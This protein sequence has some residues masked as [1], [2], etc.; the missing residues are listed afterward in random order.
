MNRLPALLA[1]AYHLTGVMVYRSID[2]CEDRTIVYGA[3]GV[4]SAFALES[5]FRWL[6]KRQCD[7]DWNTV[8]SIVLFS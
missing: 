2:W 5:L 6:P 4:C 7:S 8:L 3:L 1:P